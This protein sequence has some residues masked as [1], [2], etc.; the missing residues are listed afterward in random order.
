[1]RNTWA[2][3]STMPALMFSTIT[4]LAHVRASWSA[5]IR[6]SVSVVEPAAGGTTSLTVREGKAEGGA[7]WARVDAAAR[8]A[9]AKITS[10]AM[11]CNVLMVKGLSD[12]VAHR[13]AYQSNPFNR[14]RSR[15]VVYGSLSRRS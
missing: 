13:P 15:H 4:D 12:E 2:A 5:M 14:W 11:R 8:A 1:M 7:S 6:A 9:A 10:A 3:P